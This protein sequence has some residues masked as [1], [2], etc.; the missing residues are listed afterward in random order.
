MNKE[1]YDIIIE[2]GKA[3]NDYWKNIWRF[4]ELFYFMAWRDLLVRYK[5]TIIGVAWSVIRPLLTMLAFVIVFG[6]VAKL[7]SHGVPY[8]ILVF[9][10][11]LPW[12]LFS[13]SLAEASNSLV[14]NSNIISKIYFPRVIIPL[15]SIIVCLVDFL[16]SLI[17]FIIMLLFYKF[18]LTI[19]AIFL[20]G[21]MIMALFSAI[22]VSLWLSALTVKY[23]DFRYVVPFIVQFGL[24]ISP[25]GFDS[26]HIP[27]RWR[28]IYSLN[29]IV[30]VIDGFRWCLLGGPSTFYWPSF[31]TS[32]VSIVVLLV[33]GINY[34]RATERTFADK[35]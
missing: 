26:S 8:P 9:A 22:G 11:L 27:E 3:Q 21:F 13:S 16:F 14:T 33:I 5:Q 10:A 29:P 1:E 31:I 23:R 25:V 32:L 15:S 17:I 30:G 28:Y 35:I 4:R 19:N 7:D 18:K 6:K 12:Q 24:Y 20:P 34:F 2:A